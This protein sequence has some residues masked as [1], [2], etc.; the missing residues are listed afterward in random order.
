M[1]VGDRHG[2]GSP[3]FPSWPRHRPSPWL[4]RYSHPPTTGNAR[5][6]SAVVMDNRNPTAP[7][8]CHNRN[9][10]CAW[11]CSAS[12]LA[13]PLLGELGCEV[14][15]HEIHLLSVPLKADEG[16]KPQK[17]KSGRGSVSRRKASG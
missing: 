11:R 3:V 2:Q 1:P 9:A 6:T 10:A 15:V 8:S 7:A 12:T 13:A 5:H 4:H 14:E 16:W 17:L